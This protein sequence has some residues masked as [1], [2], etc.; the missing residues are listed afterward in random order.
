MRDLERM[1]DMCTKGQWAPRDLDWS[2]APRAMAEEDEVAVVQYFTNMAIIEQLAGAL[3]REQVRRVSHPTL[4]AIFRS[5]VTD[6]ARHAEVS[7]LLAN[8]YD[9]NKYR[10]YR[11]SPSL[12]RFFP[13]FTDAIVL[14]R[15]DVANL[16]ITV[17]E[18]VL[19]VALLRSIDDYVSDPMSHQAMELINRDESR[20]IAIDYHMFEYYASEEYQAARAS[21]PK[22]SLRERARAARAFAKLIVSA[23]PFFHDVFFV[24]MQHMKA[25]HRLREAFR[26]FQLLEVK[27]RVME[28][29]FNRFLQTTTNIYAHPLGRMFLGPLLTRLAG[30]EP[31]LMERMN[32]DAA[33]EKARGMSFE[34]L[35]EDALQAKYSS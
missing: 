31:E 32:D 30:V 16:Y 17:G 12:E 33:L 6:E 13:H 20:H 5:F 25:E 34:E 3:F 28:L 8:Y 26:R 2:G 10:T 14:L 27:P 18:L 22:A 15:D 1:L 11:P 19:D 24:P 4:K 29:P 9:V 21:A 35:A 7:R 23:K